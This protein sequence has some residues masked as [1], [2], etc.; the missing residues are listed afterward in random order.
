[1]YA[2]DSYDNAQQYL[3]MH[4]HRLNSMGV[5]K[6]NAKYFDINKG[7]TTITNGRID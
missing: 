2:F 5:S 3:N 4:R 6:V 7:L 1:M